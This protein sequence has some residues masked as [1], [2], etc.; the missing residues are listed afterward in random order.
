MDGA[1][2]GGLTRGHECVATDS[3]TKIKLDKHVSSMNN[4]NVRSRIKIT[5]ALTIG[6]G[7]A[8]AAPMAFAQSWPTKPVRIVLQFP[9]GGSTDAVARILAQS[10][11]QSL[12]QPVIIDNK[13]GA[14]G[15][16]AGDFVARAEPD[17][18]TFFL[19]TNTAMMQVPL[20][21][22][23]PPYDPVK[24]FTPV[25]LV[26]RYVYVL[27]VNP[28]VP[29]KDFSEFLTYVRSNPGR[30]GYGSYSGVT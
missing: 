4:M 10:M 30:V 9:T 13:P 29:A 11:S 22:K 6:A 12:G 23:T 24:S 25:S 17:G 1:V 2:W 5:L 8:L 7:L 18:H 27:T 14:D 3:C 15:A 28:A 20:L 19:A 21:K 16:I 26:G